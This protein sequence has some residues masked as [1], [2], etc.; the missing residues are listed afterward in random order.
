MKYLVTGGSGFIGRSLVRVL[1]A[2][3]HQVRVFD[4][5]SRG[6]YAKFGRD[7]S[8]VNLEL[9][10]GDIRNEDKVAVACQGVDSV[11]HLA[12]LNGTEYFY[13]KPE[14]VLDIG[15]RGM[16]AVIA[17]CQKANVRELLT[18]S[19]SEVYQTPPRIP[20]DEDIPLIIPDVHNPRYSYGG[21]KIISELMTINFGR[22]HFDRVM[23]IRPHNVYGPDMGK[24][25][26][27]PQLTLR[28]IE[29]MSSASCQKNI[30]LGNALD[31]PIQG[32]GQQTRAFIYI[33]DFT[34]AFMK[35]LTNGKHMEVYHIGTDEEISIREIAL[36]VVSILGV[37]VNLIP[38][39]KPLG[40]VQRR[41]PNIDKIKSFGFMPK[42]SIQE[43]I[44]QTVHWYYE[45]YL[46]FMELK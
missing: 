37:N 41:C 16:L 31:F 5:D 14:L 22:H 27:I 28:L 36:K 6:S 12:Y 20:T 42:I 35:V 38:S 9:H 15:V 19:S 23:I 17:G 43:G 10:E 11:L 33:D 1:L 29:M 8:N 2:Q 3:G 7:L 40:S 46:Q 24:E 13:E 44:K 18:M 25:H 45:Q 32:D 30:K 21:G 26:V 39:P 4:N 34:N